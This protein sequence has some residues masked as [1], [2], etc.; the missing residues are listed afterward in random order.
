MCR[1]QTDFRKLPHVHFLT[2][3]QL[4]PRYFLCRQLGLE[5]RSSSLVSIAKE[6]KVCA[7]T[8]DHKLAFIK[9]QYVGC[10]L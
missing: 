6:L 3:Q 9:M 8:A 10:E 1:L 4:L 2:F 5:Q 7:T